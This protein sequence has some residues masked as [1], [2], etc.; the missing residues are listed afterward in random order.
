MAEIEDMIAHCLRL[1]FLETKH[2]DTGD[3]IQQYVKTSS[4]YG[5][6]QAYEDSVVLGEDGSAKRWWTKNSKGE[7][8]PDGPSSKSREQFKPVIERLS[9]GERVKERIDN[10][11]PILDASLM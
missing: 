1:E 9:H 10:W 3:R 11:A 2:C 7:F 8:H 5:D 4:R 6:F